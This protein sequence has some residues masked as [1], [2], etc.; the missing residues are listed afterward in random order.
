MVSDASSRPSNGVSPAERSCPE[1]D[2]RIIEQNGESQCENCGLIVGVDRIDRGAYWTEGSATSAKHSGPGESSIRDDGGLGGVFDPQDSEDTRGMER[3]RELDA[4][5]KNNKTG[6]EQNRIHGLITIQKIGQ[7]AEIGIDVIEQ[8]GRLFETVQ[9]KGAAGSRDI[10]LVAVTCLYASLR[11][12]KIIRPAQHLA[13]H[14]DF[15][16]TDVRQTLLLIQKQSKIS[17]PPLSPVDLVPFIAS[18]LD[19]NEVR[20]LAEELVTYAE[21]ERDIGG[22]RPSGVAGGAVYTAARWRDDIEPPSQK[23][24]ADTAGVA[25][26]TIWSRYEELDAIAQSDITVPDERTN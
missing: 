18:E 2:G 25:S 10:E 17:I 15:T 12:N 6:A 24:V 11:Q 16:E 4:P 9:S 26:R 20:P 7:V 23:A 13:T 1:C 14:T 22:C 3:L 5:N 21:E 8:A 19:L